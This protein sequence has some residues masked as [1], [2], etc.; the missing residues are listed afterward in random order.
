MRKIVKVGAVSVLLLVILTPTVLANIF[1]VTD[2]LGD[3]F[4]G[5]GTYVSGYS[6]IDLR[7]ANYDNAT[8]TITI[9]TWGEMNSH[10]VSWAVAFFIYLG[11]CNP[12]ENSTLIV[13]FEYQGDGWVYAARTNATNPFDFEEDPFDYED[14]ENVT[15]L[16]EPEFSA[17][18]KSASMGGNCSLFPSQICN[19][20]VIALTAP[21]NEDDPTN[22]YFDVMPES[23]LAV[24]GKELYGENFD[25]EQM[26]DA[27]TTRLNNYTGILVLIVVIV[28]FGVC[29]N[30]VLKDRRGPDRDD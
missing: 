7:D 30:I 4:K 13:G 18:G 20:S 22:W 14:I 10:P 27:Q 3:V 29:A 6:W 25:V 23:L 16:D 9:R 21:F 11:A 8:C 15:L 2:D 26:E 19:V 12:A 5:S 1:P 17:D 28:F 24:L